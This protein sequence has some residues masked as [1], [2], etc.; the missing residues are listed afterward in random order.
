MSMATSPMVNGGL[1]RTDTIKLLKDR[2]FS[3]SFLSVG[4]V[5]TYAFEN[6]VTTLNSLKD[7]MCLKYQIHIDF[8]T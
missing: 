8:L 4:H 1:Q 3:K 6:V 5:L 2:P 7:Y